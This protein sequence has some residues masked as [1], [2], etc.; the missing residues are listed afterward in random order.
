[1]RS[2]GVT[3]M[4][5]PVTD[6]Q[7]DIYDALGID[8][9]KPERP[10]AIPPGPRFTADGI[11]L[12][13]I[14]GY[15]DGLLAD[16][17]GLA[18]RV[19]K[20]HSRKKS[21]KV[22]F[23]AQIVA[24]SMT[25]KWPAL[26]WVELHAGPGKLYEVESKELLDGSPLDALNT[27]KR[28]NGYVFV[29]FDPVCAAALRERTKGMPNVYIID[30]DCN[31]PSVHD[32]IR[33]I[34]PTNALTVMYADPEDLDDLSFDTVKFFTE[35]YPHLDWLINFPVSGAVRYL[36]A[37]NTGLGRRAALLLDH[38]NPHEL[39]A[40]CTGRTYGPTFST[41]F[42]RRLEA[43]GHECRYETIYLDGK[44]VAFYDLFLATKDTTGLAIKFFEQ[45]CDI[46][47]NG[48]RTLFAS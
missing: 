24:N 23:Y 43:L 44:N 8:P 15:G 7:M 47:A 14:P 39:L 48:Q 3:T 32:R 10:R 6:E 30:E 41:Y 28:Y 20:S 29:E 19:V 26:W 2:W 21:K 25:G 12:D 36:T 31:L 18:V 1:V 17:D 22:G 33:S 34:V 42:K 11:R 46:K 4:V 16:P 40:E 38:P 5:H 37:D 27:T 35:R 13:P 45:A 9:D